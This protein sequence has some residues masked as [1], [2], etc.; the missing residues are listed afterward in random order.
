MFL[1]GPSLLTFQKKEMFPDVLCLLCYSYVRNYHHANECRF[2]PLHPK[3]RTG[4]WCCHGPLLRR[5][6]EM[7]CIECMLVCNCRL[8]A[9]YKVCLTC[10]FCLSVS[11]QTSILQKRQHSRA[12]L[13]RCSKEL[14]ADTMSASALLFSQIKP[15]EMKT[16]ASVPPLPQCRHPARHVCVRNS[17]RVIRNDGTTGK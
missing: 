9:W 3:I 10:L 4:L 11:T 16:Y 5:R 17:A 6:T 1:P 15:H 8:Y 7:I 12:C 13:L 2:L 14:Q